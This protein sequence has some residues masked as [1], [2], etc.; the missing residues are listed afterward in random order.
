ML[1][2][3]IVEYLLLKMQGI[4]FSINRKKAFAFHL[5]E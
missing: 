2:E 3:A 5:N 4:F 1:A